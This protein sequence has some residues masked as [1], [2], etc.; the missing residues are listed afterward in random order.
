MPAG[1][2]IAK[3]EDRYV[4]RLRTLRACEFRCHTS[5]ADNAAHSLIQFRNSRELNR[6]VTCGTCRAWSHGLSNNSRSH[7]NITAVTYRGL[8]V[9]ART[10]ANLNLLLG[11]IVEVLGFTEAAASLFV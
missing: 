7:R 3:L 6:L 1:L 5:P 11:L 10:G 9:W 2:A 4:D 8:N